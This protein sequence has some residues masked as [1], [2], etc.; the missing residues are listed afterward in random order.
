[1]TEYVG[2]SRRADERRPRKTSWLAKLD[3]LES[4]R[5]DVVMANGERH[6]FVGRSPGPRAEVIVHDMAAAVRRLA[7]GDV[8]LADAYVAGEWDTPDLA[9]LLTL[10][11]ANRHVM[12]RLA[13][14]PLMRILQ[15]LRNAL[16]RNT[17]KGA[18]RNIRAHY[19]LG[20]DFYAAWLD[21]GM[22]YSSG[23]DLARDGDLE[24]SQA[25][26]FAALADALDLRPG[27][28]LLEIGC[29]WG[30]FAEYAA[31]ERGAQVTAIT[32]SPSQHGY[33]RSRIALAGLGEKVDVRLCDYRDLTGVYD[34]V[35]SIEMV[36]AVGE[37]FWPGYFRTL[38]QCTAPGGRAALQAITIR[39]DA[40]PRYRRELDFIRARIFPGGMLPT[41]TILREM[42][43]K[44]GLRPIAERAFGLD[45]AE[46]CR[47]WRERFLGAWPEIAGLGFDA[48]F[49]RLWTYYLAY[50]E[51]GFR[52]GHVD[53]RHIVFERV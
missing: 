6:V 14:N 30:G 32:I 48:A 20:D 38:A 40:F 7:G 53:V 9:G 4:G 23:L 50:C 47:L 16:N 35:A 5:L 2:S 42:G 24:A 39:E 34:R 8:G 45:Y 25:R 37:A 21:P 10:V 52:V 26:K 51:A 3:G 36:E 33:A 29:G 49:K 43:G 17:R 18:S 27:H 44:S 28:R 11:T 12:D 15:F 13:S 41:A 1:M 46:T 31:S 22:T 19:D